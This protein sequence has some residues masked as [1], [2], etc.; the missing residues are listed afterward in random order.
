[1][2]EWTASQTAPFS[3]AVLFLLT[4]ILTSGMISPQKLEFI[5]SFLL[6]VM[7]KGSGFPQFQILPCATL[8]SNLEKVALW[9]VSF[10]RFKRKRAFPQI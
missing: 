1:M 2:A 9:L 3:D 8:W 7:R 4:S 5:F 10:Y 6:I